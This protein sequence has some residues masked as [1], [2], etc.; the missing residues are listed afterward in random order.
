MN[1]YCVR[2]DYTIKEAIEVIDANQ[3]RVAV[4][5]NKSDKVIG[6]VSQ[7]DL[8]RALISGVN[9]YSQVETIVRPSF[10]Y[11]EERNLEKAYAIFKKTQITMLPI[12]DQEFHLVDVINLQDIYQYLEEKK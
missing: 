7:G 5:L 1:K 8:I 4:V 12:L 3:D 2:A 11:L 9:L 10:F 6:V